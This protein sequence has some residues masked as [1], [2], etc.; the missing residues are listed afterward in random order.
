MKN[1]LKIFVLVAVLF[2]SFDVCYSQGDSV[3]VRPRYLL[4]TTNYL[5]TANT[6]EFDIRIKQRPENEDSTVFRY[7]AGQYFL[8][9]NLN[10]ANGGTLTYSKIGSDLIPALQPINPTVFQNQLRLAT[11]L[12]SL[13]NIDTITSSDSTLV[14]R[15]RLSNTANWNWADTLNLRWMSVAPPPFTKITAF[16]GLN[17]TVLTEIQDPASNI[18]NVMSGVGNNPGVTS[19]IP[20]EFS[21]SQNYP[22]PFNPTTK[23]DFAIPMEGHVSMKIY[24][25]TGREVMNLVNE[26]RP[27]GFYSVNFNGSNLASGMYFY[28]LDVVNGGKSEFQTTRRMVLIK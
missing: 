12:P 19:L 4:Y 27:A 3:Y 10:F 18:I 25:I 2:A 8:K 22:N 6:F 17:N 28:R 11:N 26:V 16:T 14:V 7:A 5:F 9:F 15:M 13:N 24:D 20:V 1:L 21:L 23:I